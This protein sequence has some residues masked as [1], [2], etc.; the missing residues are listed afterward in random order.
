MVRASQGLRQVCLFGVLPR[1][2][3]S[4]DTYFVR[5][6]YSIESCIRESLVK[7]KWES[8]RIPCI[9]LAA[10][11]I[12]VAVYRFKGKRDQ[13]IGIRSL[14]EGW[15]NVRLEDV[16][17]VHG[18]KF[19]IAITVC[20]IAIFVISKECTRHLLV[21]VFG[22]LYIARR[23]PESRDHSQRSG[24]RTSDLHR[25]L[26]GVESRRVRASTLDAM[27]QDN[28]FTDASVPFMLAV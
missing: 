1:L 28:I 22:Q 3:D 4:R 9:R 7:F 26:D 10:D 24:V 17:Q 11:A 25:R 18:H 2:L 6:W 14:Y 5:S 13:G 8:V 15:E 23:S 16:V 12:V 21:H 20:G 19:V 27:L